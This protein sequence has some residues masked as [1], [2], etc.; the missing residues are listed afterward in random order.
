MLWPLS[1]DISD[2][3][4]D[5]EEEIVLV[6][7]CACVCVCVHACV[8]VRTYECVCVTLYLF[9]YMYVHVCIFHVHFLCLFPLSPILSSQA[10]E[11]NN[12]TLF[13]LQILRSAIVDYL[14][15]S[16]LTLV[17]NVTVPIATSSAQLRSALDRT[18]Q[19]YDS[20]TRG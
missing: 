6:C 4:R 17:K 13:G 5:V 12:P 16:Y 7:V 10:T 3:L 19:G 11:Q 14:R 18:T 20:F 1:G 2:L 15:P 9:M 8:C